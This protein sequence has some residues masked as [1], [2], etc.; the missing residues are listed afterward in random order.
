[1]CDWVH[2]APC[3]W[4]LRHE[5]QPGQTE[6]KTPR[7]PRRGLYYDAPDVKRHRAGNVADKTHG[8][9]NRLAWLRAMDPDAFGTLMTRHARG[10]REGKEKARREEVS[11]LTGL[12][13]LAETVRHSR[14]G[15]HTLP[16]PADLTRVA[17]QPAEVSPG[18]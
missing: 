2:I 6:M 12:Y 1:M 8:S 16:R 4:V 11:K 14:R 17:P 9:T 13:A 5:M 18:Q 7:R 3:Q 15:Q 10:A